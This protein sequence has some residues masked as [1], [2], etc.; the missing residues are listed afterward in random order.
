MVTECLKMCT[1]FVAPCTAYS[2]AG[3]G[4]LRDVEA[5][6]LGCSDNLRHEPTKQVGVDL[7]LEDNAFKPFVGVSTPEIVE[8]EEETVAGNCLASFEL[9]FGEQVV[10]E[11]KAEIARFDLWGLAYVRT[12]VIYASLVGGGLGSSKSND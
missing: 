10:V 5:S 9:G 3:E 7:T 11:V 12:F 1:G 2:C 8:R 4:T 6:S